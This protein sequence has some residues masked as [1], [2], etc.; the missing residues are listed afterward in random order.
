MPQ[1]V[2]TYVKTKNFEAVDRGKKRILTLYREDITRFARGYEARGLVGLYGD[3]FIKYIV[4]KGKALPAC[5]DWQGLI[6]PDL[7]AHSVFQ[8]SGGHS[9]SFFHPVKPN[10]G[11]ASSAALSDQ[12]TLQIR[13][14]IVPWRFREHHRSAEPSQGTT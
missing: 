12:E 13:K 14:K 6:D 10:G 5:K 4:L 8:S 11:V 7:K 3:V 9:P 2:E 1:A